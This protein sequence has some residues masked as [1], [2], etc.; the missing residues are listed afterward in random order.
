[1]GVPGSHGGPEGSGG[2]QGGP[3]REWTG[4]DVE[5]TGEDGR[6]KTGDTS[7]HQPITLLPR[8]PTPPRLRMCD[9]EAVTSLTNLL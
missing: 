7:R 3:R 6:R 4:A 1:M 5:R 9:G 2:S 8:Q